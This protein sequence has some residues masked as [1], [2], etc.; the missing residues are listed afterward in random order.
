VA[1]SCKTTDPPSI[2]KSRD[3]GSPAHRLAAARRVRYTFLVS[4]TEII[5]QIKRLP[6]EEKAEVILFA[7]R[8][9]RN[10]SQDFRIADDA[11]LQKEVDYVFHHYADL[12]RKLAS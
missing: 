8:L 10:K 2:P 4:A 3:P 7:C 11:A 12:M 9:A 6:A 1:Q 5:E